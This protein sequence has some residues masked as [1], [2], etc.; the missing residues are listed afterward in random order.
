MEYYP[1][2]VQAVAGDGYCVNAYFSDGTIR[3]FDMKPLIDKG[4]VFAQLSDAT[5]FSS[6]L[7]VMG[8]T[9][10]WD[11]AGNRDETKCI[12]LNP[13]NLYENSE[14]TSDPLDRKAKD[15]SPEPAEEVE[16]T[17]VYDGYIDGSFYGFDDQ[18]VFK[19]KDGSYW[20]Q[21]NYRYWEYVT[22]NPKV[23][24]EDVGGKL[25]MTVAGESTEVERLEGVE[26]VTINGEFDGWN[27]K[28]SY[29]LSD[30]RKW[31]EIGYR[32]KYRR[33]DDPDAFI[34]RHG[35]ATLMYVDGIHA[36]VEPVDSGS[37][38]AGEGLPPSE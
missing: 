1:E 30:G 24:I 6:R 32:Y 18:A 17:V 9:V 34:V 21:V 38:E 5:F 36:R 7:T 35:E 31:E 26:E 3:K 16:R 28:R 15:S 37:K 22:H 8:G 23:L 25:I 14:S 27:G 4:G 20:R 13:F 10:A 29:T 12:D 19:T 2:V 11:V 33:A